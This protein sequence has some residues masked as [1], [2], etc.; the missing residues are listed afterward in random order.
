MKLGCCLNMNAKGDF[1]IGEES[2]PLFSKLGYDYI[3]LPLAQ[4]MDLQEDAFRSLLS[5]IKSGGIP[6]ET[7]N[8]FFPANIRLTGENATP[9][10]ALEYAKRAC[11]RA[12]QM[13][14]K[15]IVF[16]SSGAKNI[17]EGFPYSE[18]RRQYIDLLG[19]LQDIVLPLGITV[20]LEALNTKE[21]NFILSISEALAAMNEVSCSNIKLLAD[22]Y[23]MRMED[24][25]ISILHSVGKDL[26]HV[27]IAARDGRVFPK[28]GDGEDY[29]GF[30]NV[31]KDIGYSGGVSVEAYS[32]DL[33]QEA[34]SV[35][36]LLRPLM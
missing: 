2:I 30:F 1:K 8:N 24:E 17:P 26:R 22:Y 28:Q 20:A 21:S 31:L 4:V 34:L 36:E 18:A 32:D 29:T 23:H 13:G 19:M 27:H 25:D 5:D 16:G 14:A 35:S 6:M 9:D 7:C 3:E 12:A 11:D 15:I 33:A 10:I